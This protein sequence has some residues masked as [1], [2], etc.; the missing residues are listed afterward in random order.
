MFG[1]YSSKVIIRNVA[2]SE[3]QNI[4][5]II[6]RLNIYTYNA[7]YILNFYSTIIM[8]GLYSYFIQIKT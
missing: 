4:L 7:S 3:S 5:H 6:K 8:N 1:S 2:L